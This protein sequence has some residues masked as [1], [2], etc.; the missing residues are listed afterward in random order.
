LREATPDVAVT[1]YGWRCE[2]S[3]TTHT[4]TCTQP[5]SPSAPAVT[6]TDVLDVTSTYNAFCAVRTDASV[7]CGRVD[8]LGA[9]LAF[10]PSTH[11]PPAR[12]ITFATSQPC[13]VTRDAGEIVCE[14]TLHS[15]ERGLEIY[16]PPTPAS[17]ASATAAPTSAP[18]SPAPTS[19]APTTAPA[20]PG[21]VRFRGLRDVVQVSRHGAAR[22][23]DG[24]V[25]RFGTGVSE[26][27]AVTDHADAILDGTVFSCVRRV[28]EQGGEVICWGTGS[29]GQLAQAEP[30]T[31]T[32]RIPGLDVPLPPPVE[33][34]PPIDLATHGVVELAVGGGNA[35]ARLS[36]GRMLCWGADD[37]GQ[38]GRA[39]EEL[40]LRPVVVLE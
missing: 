5:A 37:E 12:A 24:R 32:V 28:G 17:E 11:L 22:L 21:L 14:G 7:S 39:P 29:S 4:L 19:P 38:L 18:T 6:L 36:D 26:P 35:C 31:G 1:A 2:L 3:A 10:A 23:S 16:V 13:V 33:G 9:P 8:S 27:I 25:V 15:Y 34:Q 20:G 40:R 30:T